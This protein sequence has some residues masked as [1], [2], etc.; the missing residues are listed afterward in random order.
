[1]HN[2]PDLWDAV[3]SHVRSSFPEAVVAG[4]CVRDYLTNRP[5]KDIDVFVDGSMPMGEFEK[6]TALEG[7]HFKA[8]RQYDPAY[9]KD[10]GSDT[11]CVYVATFLATVAATEIEVQLIF[12]DLSQMGGWSTERAIDRI[13]FGICR[14][15]STDR[16][17]RS[18]VLKLHHG[19][20]FW[21]DYHLQRF[22]VLRA[23]SPKQLAASRK[24]HERLSAKFVGWPFVV[25]PPL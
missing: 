18:G 20:G 4:G 12:L 13:D 9:D 6:L 1:M 22:T 10:E 21:G 23:E 11:T 15:G 3:L 2:G 19:T 17:S 24:R 8:L 16:S 14:V 25:A 7:E 5:A